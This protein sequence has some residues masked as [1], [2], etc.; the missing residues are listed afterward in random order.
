MFKLVTNDK[1][2][3]LRDFKEDDIAH[4]VRFNTIKTGW[5]DLDAPWEKPDTFDEKTEWHRWKEYYE[6]KKA[7]PS[8]ALKT[9]LQICENGSSQPIGWVSSYPIDTNY[10]FSKNGE[11]RA[12]GIVIPD[13]KNRGRGYGTKAL[14]TYIDYLRKSGFSTL[15]T[16]TWSGN[17]PMIHLAKTLGFK[18]CHRIKDARLVKGQY[19]DALTF[20]LDSTSQTT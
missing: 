13:K 7:L 20:R 14:S 4:Y 18:E 2:L 17:K 12:V 10:R 19:Y 5:M 15:F 11:R 16:Q 8:D 6:H 1:T 3:I 9:R